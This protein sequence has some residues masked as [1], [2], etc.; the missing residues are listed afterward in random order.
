MCVGVGARSAGF[1]SHSAVG[2]PLFWFDARSDTLAFW[3]SEQVP[4][5]FRPRGFDQVKTS[6]A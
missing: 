2:T 5:R 6:V 4:D 3:F 1:Q